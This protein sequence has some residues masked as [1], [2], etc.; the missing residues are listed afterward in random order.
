VQ[1]TPDFLPILSAVAT[2]P[3]FFIATGFSGHGFG[4]APGVGHLMADLITGG[5]PLVDPK[6]FDFARLAA[7]QPEVATQTAGFP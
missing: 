5:A 7:F 2:L 6:P 4:I 3:G 1:L